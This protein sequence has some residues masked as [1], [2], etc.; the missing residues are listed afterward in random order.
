MINL[1]PQKGFRDLY[2]KDK[3]AQEFVFK[4]LEKAARLFGFE[5]YDGP[6]LEPI[7][8]YLNKTSRELIERQTFQVKDKK[9]NILILRP[10]MTPSL[11]RMIANKAG[12]LTFPTR[13]FNLGLRFRY[14]APQKGRE[15][16]FYQA[17]YDILG[18]ENII[19]DAEIIAIAVKIFLLL[20][21]AENDFIVY[22]NSRVEMEKKLLILGFNKEQV[23]PLLN[24][25]DKQD[26]LPNEVFI[27]T[28]L[29][30]EPDKNKIKQLVDFLNAARKEDS[31]YFKELFDLLDRYKIS[32]YCQI[33]YNVTRGLDYYTGLVFE[34]KEKGGMKRSL[35]GGGRYDNLVSSYKENL[36][37]PGVG[38]ATSDVV[39]LEF[40]RDK[41]LLPQVNPKPTKVLVTIF[42][43]QL[44]PIS[45]KITNDLRSENISAEL[46]PDKN[47]KLDK[48][49]KYADRSKIP[50]A[51]IIGPEEAE[52]QTVKVKNMST[53]EQ[54]ELTE[55]KLF[56]FFE[57]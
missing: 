6:I 3:T 17:D 22:I 28:L 24:S 54:N 2:P 18:S 36:K 16:E 45:L 1:N 33:N 11:A 25:I 46:Y 30:I 10:E 55:D 44:T 20:G 35:L 15:R 52:K 39:L 32:R 12:E 42:S 51:V 37:I 14:E 47:A 48:Q 41:N 13:L 27:N 56:K 31:R 43:P 53:G 9:E 34:V 7:D 50:Y 23:K 21:A 4:K 40:L 38:F 57:Q 8:I 5:K 29:A 26:K 49:L 19:A